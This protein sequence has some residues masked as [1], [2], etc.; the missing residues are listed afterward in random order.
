MLAHAPLQG[1]TL[2]FSHTPPPKMGPHPPTEN[3]GSS[4][5]LDWL[6]YNILALHTV[7]ACAQTCPYISNPN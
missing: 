3:P 5:D 6:G 4:P 1:P 2:S 7:T